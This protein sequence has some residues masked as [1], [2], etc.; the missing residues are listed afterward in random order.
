M[1]LCLTYAVLHIYKTIYLYPDIFLCVYGDLLW[2][3]W[4]HVSGNFLQIESR[5]A[6]LLFVIVPS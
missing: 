2:C 4:D 5:G 3:L 6:E 1:T